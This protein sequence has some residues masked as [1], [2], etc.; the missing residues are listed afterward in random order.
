MST[1]SRGYVTFIVHCPE[2]H[3]RL[4]A[5]PNDGSGTTVYAHGNKADCSGEGASIE[6]PTVTVEQL[7]EAFPAPKK[8]ATKKKASK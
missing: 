5:Q 8:A 3:Q 4:Q 1:E 7:E 6:L 2:C